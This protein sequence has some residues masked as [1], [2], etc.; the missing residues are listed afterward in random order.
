MSVMPGRWLFDVVLVGFVIN[1]TVLFV[2]MG[3]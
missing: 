1:A 3:A 2:F